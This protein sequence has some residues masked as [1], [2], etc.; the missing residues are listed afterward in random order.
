MGAESLSREG[1]VSIGNVLSRNDLQTSQYVIELR[2]L[3]SP[4]K[5]QR[6]A[7]SSQP[8]WTFSGLADGEY[9]VRV[10]D[11]ATTY[12]TQKFTVRHWSIEQALMLFTVGLLMF[13]S[14]LFQLHRFQR[15][16]ESGEDLI[17]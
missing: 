8:A 10:R 15:R 2:E 5:V 14:L 1:F 6:Y 11:D 9:E 16:A 7:Y 17:E 3:S 12:S 13:L 4:Q